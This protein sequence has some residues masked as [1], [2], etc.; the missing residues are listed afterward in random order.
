MTSEDPISSR[1]RSLPQEEPS[2]ALDARILAAA[3]AESVRRPWWPKFV[4]AAAVVVLSI[5]VVTRIDFEPELQETLDSA[6]GQS[7][8]AAS[9]IRSLSDQAPNADAAE[10]SET[11]DRLIPEPADAEIARR[12]QPAAPATPSSDQPQT[13][14]GLRQEVPALEERIVTQRPEPAQSTG[15]A[16]AAKATAEGQASGASLCP[17]EARSDAQAWWTCIQRLQAA[18]EPGVAAEIEAYRAV[19]GDPPAAP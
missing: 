4:A 13:D 14:A 15:F 2:A 3:Q 16:A 12:A 10:E 17:T 7:T 11:V 18:Q 9:D 8:P 1:Y 5:G 19:H 6:E